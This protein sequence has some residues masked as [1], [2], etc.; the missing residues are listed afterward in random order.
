MKKRVVT[1]SISED[2]VKMISEM[3]ANRPEIAHKSQLI[4]VAV[5]NEYARYMKQKDKK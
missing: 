1:F 4:E 5:T 3:N 2:V